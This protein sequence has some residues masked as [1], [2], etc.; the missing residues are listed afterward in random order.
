MMTR[1]VS[2]ALLTVL[3]VTA[4][5]S[6]ATLQ[7]LGAPALEARIVGSSATSLYVE[8]DAGRRYRVP[9]A[10]VLDVDHPGNVAL[11]FGLGCLAVSAAMYF[12]HDGSESADDEH[13]REL[14]S[15]GYAVPGVLL[16]A[17]GGY[18]WF[19]STS[20]AAHATPEPAMPMPTVVPVAPADVVLPPGVSPPR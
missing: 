4:C 13:A 12:D 9:R 18:V 10:S 2:L 1:L 14:A 16:A 20:A 11:A 5:G 19:D 15:F 6:T 8:D 3:G 17:W 7:R